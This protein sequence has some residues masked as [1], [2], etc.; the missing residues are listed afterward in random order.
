MGRGGEVGWVVCRG[1]GGGE[2][3]IRVLGV[4]YSLGGNIVFKSYSF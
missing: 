2:D 3:T 1:V 4:G